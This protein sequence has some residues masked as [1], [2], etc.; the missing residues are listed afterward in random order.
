MADLSAIICSL[1]YEFCPGVLVALLRLPYVFYAKQTREINN[2]T[3]TSCYFN[4]NGME[5]KRPG[6]DTIRT[7]VLPSKPKWETTKA[8]N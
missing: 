6:T 4:V 5:S 8:T 2:K 7:K 3:H 1:F